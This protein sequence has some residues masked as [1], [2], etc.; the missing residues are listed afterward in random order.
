MKQGIIKE[1]CLGQYPEARS[2]TPV[3]A[4]VSIQALRAALAL[5]PE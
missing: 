3:A 4:D 2:Q 5:L 1:P